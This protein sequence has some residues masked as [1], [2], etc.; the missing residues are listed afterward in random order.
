[1]ILR[2]SIRLLVC[3]AA[4]GP[5]MGVAASA[6]RPGQVQFSDGEMLEGAISLT[7]GA[8][9]T[10][11]TGHGLRSASSEK[12]QSLTFAPE[13]E[14]MV[15]KWRFIEAGKTQK[16]TDGD[17]Y[18]TRQLRATLLLAGGEQISGHLYTTV[19]YIDTHDKTQKVVLWAKQRG[20]EGQSLAALV[21]PSR[22][23]FRNTPEP[24]PNGLRVVVRSSSATDKCEIAA[25]TYGSLIRL[26]ATPGGDS[27]SYDLPSG[28]G[29][30][31][32]LAAKVGQ[33]ITVN[34]PFQAPEPF[35]ALV[36]T[37]LA[38]A[39]DFFDHRELLACF[40]DAAERDVYS[41][42][43]L[44]RQGETTLSAE[45]NRPW[46]LVILRWKYEPEGQR[47]LLAGRGYFYRS[48]VTPGGALPSIRM[49]TNS[50]KSGTQ[51]NINLERRA[52]W[53]ERIP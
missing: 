12:V 10:V 27:A 9:I 14:E 28:L 41:L 19:L 45:K 26:E 25:L 17:P 5:L 38:L 50:W 20:K 32:F 42:L 39:D 34:W 18:P 16:Q 11:D 48:I 46:R 44:V 35:P 53:N 7:P 24:E 8:E 6:E 43:L 30:K 33:T 15:Q 2:T 4:V 29:A 36:R 37:N 21:Y 22:V 13:H 3:L 52:G 47:L 51:V 49:E 40:Y 31:L 23:L 1:M